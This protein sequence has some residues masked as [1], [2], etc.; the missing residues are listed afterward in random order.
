MRK[1]FFFKGNRPLINFQYHFV[2]GGKHGKY[3]GECVGEVEN[4]L[5]NNSKN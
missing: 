5:S 2:F 3:Y 1:P 4:L